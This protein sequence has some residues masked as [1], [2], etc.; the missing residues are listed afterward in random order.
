VQEAIICHVLTLNIGL[1]SVRPK[2]SK[3]DKAGAI[4]TIAL[5][6]RERSG[7]VVADSSAPETAVGLSNT[8]RELSPGPKAVNYAV[9]SGKTVRLSGEPYA[10][11]P[12]FL[13]ALR[14]VEEMGNARMFMQTE[15]EG[16]AAN[17]ITG[18]QRCP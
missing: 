16:S 13:I 4:L 9:K 15:F 10:R 14:L 1:C 18:G 3:L 17:I 7:S 5:I 12:Y 2:S 8:H 11:D 6:W